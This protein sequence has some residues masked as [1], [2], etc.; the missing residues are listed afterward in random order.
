MNA[1]CLI[2]RSPD[3]IW[4]DLLNQFENYD[5]YVVIDSEI[6]DI[7]P[8]I[9]NYKNIKF[10]S[11]NHELC[12]SSGYTNMNYLMKKSV[13]GWEKAIYFFT[14]VNCNHQYVW[15]VEDDVF[16]MSENTVTMIDNKYSNADLLSNCITENLTGKKN[17]WHWNKIDISYDP[18]YYKGMMCA[19]RMSKYMLNCIKNY[20][21]TNGTLFF[22]E[23]M[24]PTIAMKNNLIHNFP[25]E[26]STIRYDRN[27]NTSDIYPTHMYHPVKNI[28]DHVKFREP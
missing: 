23:A 22:L 1:L 19:V 2:C 13:T 7:D 20:A 21:V 18:P 10:V 4:C 17:T 5:V 9:A 27:Y 6:C 25:L 16:F 15:F 14:I 11:I 24:F 26:M 12:V 28:A 3:K 8:F